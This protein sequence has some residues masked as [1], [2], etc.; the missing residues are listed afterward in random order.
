MSTLIIAAG[1]VHRGDEAAPGRVL[2]LLGDQ[3][4]VQVQ[5]VQ[6]LSPGL[7]ADMSAVEE[8]VFIN[9]H[10]SLGDPWMEPVGTSESD[11]TARVVNLARSLFDFHG[12]AYACHVPGIDFDEGMTLSPYA[13]SH[14]L[15]AA[16]LVRRILSGD[17]HQT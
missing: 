9:S 12:H 13:E 1:D 7:A 10:A 8:V 4:N 11:E 16:G 3:P 17:R 5:Q 14:A 6:S 2:E 15:Q